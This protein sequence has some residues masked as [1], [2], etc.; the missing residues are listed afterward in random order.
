MGTF[1]LKDAPNIGTVDSAERFVVDG[2]NGVRSIAKS[3][4][5]TDLAAV[6]KAAPSTFKLATLDSGNKVPTTQLPASLSGSLNYKG[7]I[8]GA[9][10]PATST[11]AGDYYVISSAGTSQSKTWA[12][13]D[14]A[15]YEGTS[16]NWS[17]IAAGAD[18][19]AVNNLSDVADVFTSLQNVDGE[20]RGGPQ[21]AII[22][23]GNTAVNSAVKTQLVGQPLGTGDVSISV[24]FE[25]P[26]DAT[27]AFGVCYLGDG[28]SGDSG[29]SLSIDIS[30][31]TLRVGNKVSST[32][33][34]KTSSGFVVA[35]GGR[36]VRL[37]VTRA[38]SAMAC[39]LN[40]VLFL[41]ET[42]SSWATNLGT[43]PYLQVGTRSG[44]DTFLGE[45]HR[46]QVWNLALTAAEVKMNI[47][48]GIPF[49]YR[50]GTAVDL[51]NSTTPTLNGGF[52]TAG[53]GGADVF[54]S[55]A[56]A[57][58]G[59]STLN[60]ETTAFHGGAHA[61]RMDIDGSNSLAQVSQSLLTL[62]KAYRVDLWA[63]SSSGTPDISIGCASGT[64]GTHYHI[65]TLSASYA[66]ITKR[67][68]ANN[69]SFVIKRSSA[70]GL[71]LYVDDVTLTPVGCICDLDFSVGKG[72]FFPDRSSNRFGAVG[73]TTVSPVHRF[74][75]N[76]GNYVRVVTFAHGDISATAATTK[77]LD[78]PPNCA[79]EE[80][81][82]DREA[83]FD[84]GITLDVGITG[85]TGKFVSAQAVD[86]T[87]KVRV[88]SGSL[89]SESASAWTSVWIKKS[90]STT[91]GST[92]V[93]VVVKIRG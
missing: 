88:A 87:G 50:W 74:E 40:G 17:Q 49:K 57:V 16:G 44:S 24:K 25:V 9:S 6:I 93:R 92:K 56:E 54:A 62:G 53:G 5:V 52:E 13:G 33:H 43:S 29:N 32:Y 68:E 12:V 90:G 70:T 7:G 47:R 80:I 42:D 20:P 65:V 69:A 18:L 59:T 48:T 55:W 35:Y 89:V 38:G 19:A 85:T 11:A 37:D 63:K 10:V 46:A 75:R 86:A 91:V 71:S 78:L 41:S 39:Y 67:F 84:A 4:L 51:I 31:G 77:L 28:A 27:R 3:D 72:L 64:S 21:P 30:S 81:E 73:Q 79:V 36:V 60:D 61:C 45:V 8:A 66:Q 34:S 1:R 2:A 58:A 76:Y 15:I 26:T 83:A 82:F 22:F 14:L 23:D